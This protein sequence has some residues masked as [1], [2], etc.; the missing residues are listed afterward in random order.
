MDVGPTEVIRVKAEPLTVAAAMNRLL[1]AGWTLQAPSIERLRLLRPAD[2][3]E[4]LGVGSN[5]AREIVH[6]L[7]N[8]VRLPGDDLRARP[9]DLEEWI[10]SHRLSG[11]LPNSQSKL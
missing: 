8:S 7:P 11:R 10:S 1:A 4:I 2:V 6:A 3:A 5:R 9:S